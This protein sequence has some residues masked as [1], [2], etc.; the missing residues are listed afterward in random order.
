[1]YNILMKCKKVHIF[2]NTQSPE[3]HMVWE[4]SSKA[5]KNRA[6]NSKKQRKENQIKKFLS[7]YC[8]FLNISASFSCEREEGGSAYI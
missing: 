4:L 2:I 3:K 5:S 6:K 8:S 7:I 1:M